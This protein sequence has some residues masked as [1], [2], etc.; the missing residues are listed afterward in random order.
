MKT[1]HLNKQTQGRSCLNKKANLQQM[2]GNQNHTQVC[3]LKNKSSDSLRMFSPLTRF[4]LLCKPIY[5]L[6]TS[7]NLKTSWGHFV[8]EAYTQMVKCGDL[9][10][11]IQIRDEIRFPFCTYGR[12]FSCNH[13]SRY[14]HW[15]P[16]KMPT[17]IKE[18]QDSALADLPLKKIIFKF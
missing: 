3:R 18:A 10:A 13:S 8:N 17:I 9:Q 16:Y 15:L 2:T 6:K 11:Y 5:I 7:P 12:Y 1:K 14:N 4:V